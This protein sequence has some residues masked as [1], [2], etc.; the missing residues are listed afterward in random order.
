MLGAER[1]PLA[2]SKAQPGVFPLALYRSFLNLVRTTGM[3]F[4][5]EAGKVPGGGWVAGRH[6]PT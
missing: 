2:D 4:E 3:F 1:L 5:T 6:E